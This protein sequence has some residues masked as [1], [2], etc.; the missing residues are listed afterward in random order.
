MTYKIFQRTFNS[1][2]TDRD[3]VTEVHNYSVSTN[4]V[5]GTDISTPLGILTEEQCLTNEDAYGCS[6]PRSSELLAWLHREQKRNPHMKL[7]GVG[8]RT[9]RLRLKFQSPQIRSNSLSESTYSTGEKVI[10]MPCDP[11]KRKMDIDLDT[12]K[13]AYSTGLHNIPFRM[14]ANIAGTGGT[15]LEARFSST[16]LGN[17]IT[18]PP[19]GGEIDAHKTAGSITIDEDFTLN[20][21][22]S[23]SNAITKANSSTGTRN[24]ISIYLL[25]G[26]KTDTFPP[27]LSGDPS[28]NNRPFYMWEEEE[29]MKYFSNGSAD[30][31]YNTTF[32]PYFRNFHPDDTQDCCCVLNQKVEDFKINGQNKYSLENFEELLTYDS[33]C[34]DKFVYMIENH[35]RVVG[36]AELQE[37]VSIPSDEAVSFQFKYDIDLELTYM[38]PGRN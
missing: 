3:F 30:F 23:T 15:V 5:D 25:R 29:C 22:E 16:E 20:V 37:G 32:E 6:R 7:V 1:T 13:A 21:P 10:T 26:L 14:N 33:L 34:F 12:D 31:V 24:D 8:F 36:D 28:C 35:N 9:G 19:G 4:P 18:V 11:K 27:M 38:D 17:N 2:W